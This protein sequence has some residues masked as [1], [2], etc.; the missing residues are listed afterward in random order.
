MSEQGQRGDS[1][2]YTTPDV[3]QTQSG[4]DIYQTPDTSGDHYD[5]GGIFSGEQQTDNVYNSVQNGSYGNVSY[6]NGQY[7]NDQNGNVP[8]ENA[9]AESGQYDIV[10]YENDQSGNDQYENASYGSDQYGN[11]PYGN[12]QYGNG[13]YGSDPY[14]NASYGNNQYGGASHGNASYGS[15]QYGNTPYGNSQYGNDS[16]GNGQY[17]N[18]QYGNVSYGNASYGSSQYGNN[19]YGNASYGNDQYGGSQYGGPY[20]PN[21]YGNTPYS[22]YAAPLRKKHTGLIIGIIITVVVLFLIALFA[23]F[24]HAF[25][26]MADRKM[27]AQLID[28]DNNDNNYDFDQD[29]DHKYEYDQDDYDYDHGYDED[30]YYTLHE[31]NKKL[32]YSINWEYFEYDADNENVSIIVDYPEVS[33]SH[34]PNLDKINRAIANEISVFTDYYEEEYSK[35]MTDNDSYFNAYASGYVT[36]MSEDVLSVVFSETVYTNYYNSAYLYCINIDMRDGVILENT[37]II[38]VDD[39]FSVDFR[40]RSDEQNGTIDGVDRMSDQEITE[41]LTSDSSLIIFYTPQGMEIGFNY[42]EGWVTVTY[43]DYRD[44]LKIF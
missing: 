38:S 44:Y 34:V 39:V 42:D 15:N 35:Y 11:A 9:S 14:G 24:Y 30:E 12:G 33:G 3:Y 7:E 43:H 32:S 5:T 40:Y 10:K 13:P 16:Y 1:G 4:Q 31:D 36:Y 29:Y 8:Y 41:L 25:D 17:G 19:Q 6:E 18:N 23:L 28:Y 27:R 21:Q 37:D 22:P 26:V 20:G 2:L